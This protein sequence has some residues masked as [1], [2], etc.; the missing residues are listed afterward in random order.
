MYAPSGLRRETGEEDRPA[1]GRP[2]LVAVGG[3]LREWSRE[4]ARSRPV[5]PSDPDRA[6]TTE[7]DSAAVW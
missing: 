6:I 1:I 4:L 2:F 7:R 5:A 3:V